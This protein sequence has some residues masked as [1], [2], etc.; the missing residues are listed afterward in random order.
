M[1]SLCILLLYASLLRKHVALIAFEQTFEIEP[2]SIVFL[3]IINVHFTKF[4]KELKNE[5]EDEDEK[6]K[7]QNEIK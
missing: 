1:F 7:L 3:K 4:Y 2:K 5:D 6:R